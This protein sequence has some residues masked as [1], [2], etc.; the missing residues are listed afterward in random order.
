MPG[1]GLLCRYPAYALAMLLFVADFSLLAVSYQ[2]A[3][4]A[5]ALQSQPPS[6]RFWQ[7]RPTQSGT[8]G[9]GRRAG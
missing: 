1:Q 4:F 6:R 3:L 8:S 2:V 9:P 5:Y 7:V